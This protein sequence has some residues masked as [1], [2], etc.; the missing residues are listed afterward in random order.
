MKR[1][2]LILLFVFGLWGSRGTG[3]CETLMYAPSSVEHSFPGG[4]WS[5]A[6]GEE[7]ISSAETGSEAA[8]RMAWRAAEDTVLLVNKPDKS[9]FWK[10]PGI[11]IDNSAGLF[12]V[13]G[14]VITNDLPTHQENQFNG[15]P[16]RIGADGLSVWS[17]EATTYV[18]F[19]NSV[20]LTSSQ[21]WKS[22]KLRVVEDA[23]T[24]QLRG[25]V[26]S[27]GAEP[28]TWT[29]DG[30]G[31]VDPSKKSVSIARPSFGLYAENS[32]SGDVCVQNGAFLYLM[33]TE[34]APGNKLNPASTVTLAGAGFGMSGNKAAYTQEVARLVLKS[35][36]NYI[37]GK[38]AKCAI[39][40]GEIVRELGATMKFPVS[41]AGGITALVNNTAN[42]DGVLGGWTTL[43]DGAFAFFNTSTGVIGQ[44]SGTQR[45]TTDNWSDNIHIVVYGSGERTKGD[46]NP[47]SLRY[48]NNSSASLTAHTNDLGGAVVT[49]KTGGVIANTTNE[50]IFRNG[51]LTS[52]ME[53]GELFLFVNTGFRMEGTIADSEATPLHLV[54]AL[55]GTLTCAGEL[56]YTGTTFLNGG[57]LVLAGAGARLTG[58][59]RQSGGTVLE[60]RDGGGLVSDLTGRTL[61]GNAVFAD[62][63]SLELYPVLEEGALPLRFTNRYAT[64]RFDVAADPIVLKIREDENSKLSRGRYPLISCEEVANV[65]GLSPEAFLPEMPEHL[66]GTLVV[67]GKTLLLDVSYDSRFSCI[68]IR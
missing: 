3:L 56:T 29:F 13:K 30:M 33:Y 68:F 21:T 22:E 66:G 49:V 25:E 58:P 6:G 7:W 1:I 4:T 36:E 43:N 10:S 12:A 11:T 53:T 24:V 9:I 52:G 14:I 46:V 16:L 62:G 67:E 64:V 55:Q 35:G 63:A 42:V 59:I 57:T 37:A 27:E 45:T 2:L 26:A 32:F 50:S 47:Y 60:C 61:G 38:N 23:A 65:E 34:E 39:V 28:M 31:I 15:D 8:T 41:W 54:K 20:V 44:Q 5:W 19:S 18:V 40:I 48:A 17:G 51:V